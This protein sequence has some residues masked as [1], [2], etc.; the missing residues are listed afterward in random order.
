MRLSV[1]YRFIITLL[2]FFL[3]GYI[4]LP[5]VF[6][7]NAGI[8]YLT[9]D[10]IILFVILLF[11]LFALAYNET[12]RNELLRTI[13]SHKSLFIFFGFFLFFLVLSVINTEGGGNY[14]TLINNSLYLVVPI[15]AFS[16]IAYNNFN[17]L[18]SNTLVIACIVVIVI[19]LIELISGSNPFSRL[20]NM[21]S[22]TEFQLASFD[23]K[24][25][26]GA[27]RVQ[28]SFANPL[29]LGQFIVM[30]L[31]ILYFFF[32]KKV[33]NKLWF[34]LIAFSLL[35]LSLYIR[36]RGVTIILIGLMLFGGYYFLFKSKVNYA[37]KAIFIVLIP[38]ALFVFVQFF[39][40]NFIAEFFGGNEI[41][42]DQ[43]RLSQIEKA[44]PLIY[45]KLY[46]GYG[47]TKG[48]VYLDYGAQDGY[49]TV[50][51]YFLTL[52]L[53]GGIFLLIAFA[54]LLIVIVTKFFKA[55]NTNKFLI[56]GLMFF[57]LNLFTLSTFEIH[58]IF[59]FFL[60][61]VIYNEKESR[62]SDNPNQLR[63]S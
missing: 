27:R 38:V 6:A 28:S 21:E 56:L 62:Y 12:V 37:F 4:T 5:Q 47:F 58:P 24:F 59:Y 29:N 52:L 25:R 39:T 20:V 32:V 15:V 43:N 44:I 31:P 40:S 23:D 60:G 34:Y 41:L 14:K 36:S 9:I 8:V 57:G 46:T 16:S 45:D 51:N 61:L 13:S 33:L 53:D 11:L 17:K 30:I 1:F 54:S 22:L 2:C 50:D 26:D 19:G 48:V 3:V 10:K 55:N 35:F 49:G 18:I 63:Q 7:F 42:S